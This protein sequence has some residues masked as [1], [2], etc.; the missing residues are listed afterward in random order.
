MIFLC[1]LDATQALAVSFFPFIHKKRR[2][3]LF[4]NIPHLKTFLSIC[5][6]HA[7]GHEMLRGIAIQT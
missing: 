5:I 7:Q 3:S 6:Q 1:Y 4:L 2:R